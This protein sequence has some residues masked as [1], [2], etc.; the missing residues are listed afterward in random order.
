[1]TTREFILKS[2]LATAFLAL[3]AYSIYQYRE[4]EVERERRRPIYHEED[5][6][7]IPA[8]EFLMGSP[9][10]DNE[11]QDIEKPRH[12]VKITK[13]FKMSRYEVTFEECDRF[14]Y[15]TNRRSPS[16]SGFGEGKR[17]RLPVINVSWEEAVA[18]AKWLSQET[19]KHFRLPTEA[20]WEYAAR[21]G[22]TD[23]RSWGDE[24]ANAC[25]FANVFDKRNE[26][27]IRQRFSVPAMWAAHHDCEDAYST[28]APV[29]SF[30]A[31][32]WGLHDM[33]GNVWEWVQ[34]CPHDNYIGA[35]TLGSQSWEA[36]NGGDCSKRVVRGGS[37]FVAP[38]YV[39]VAHRSW[40]DPDDR[41]SGL[42]FRLLQD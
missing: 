39:R 8:G 35:P 41:G 1:M 40:N 10:S 31:N 17:K 30:K 38:R 20:E 15:A 32:A 33:L 37:W 18:Y 24:P 16:D 13:S 12:R 22:T 5:W 21:A 26:A 11:A 6:V 29:G 23:K 34:D 7:H 27:R 36:E 19:G 4:F 9:D 3:S 25:E 28:I 2:S 42:G 14:A